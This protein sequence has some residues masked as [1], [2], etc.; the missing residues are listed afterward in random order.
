MLQI[1]ISIAMRCP[2]RLQIKANI[3]NKH[4]D[5]VPTKQTQHVND[6]CS[7]FLHKIPSIH[8]TWHVCSLQRILQLNNYKVYDS[9]RNYQYKT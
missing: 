3:C 1:C 7:I 9:F 8:K 4:G 6:N 2:K 5:M